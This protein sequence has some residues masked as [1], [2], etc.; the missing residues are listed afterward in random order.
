MKI[1]YT[2]LVVKFMASV[3]GGSNVKVTE[4]AF[5]GEM[6]MTYYYYRFWVPFFATKKKIMVLAIA[7]FMA[8]C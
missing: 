6:K 3:M 1:G 5:F 8:L 4:T 2:T 7:S